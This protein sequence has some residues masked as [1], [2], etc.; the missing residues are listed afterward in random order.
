MPGETT[1]TLKATVL[2]TGCYSVATK[3]LPDDLLPPTGVVVTTPSYCTDA[4]R[5]DV[6]SVIF[7]VTNKEAISIR[8]IYWEYLGEL[9]PFTDPGAIIGSGTQVFN[10]PVG[11]YRTRFYSGDYCPGEAMGQVKT[12]I[13]SFNLVSDNGDNSNETWIID[14]ISNFTIA[15]GAKRDNNVKVFN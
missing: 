4:N 3:L 11:Y 14:C 8:D 6:G 1:Y 2:A 5:G 15:G 12:E 9:P 7:N 10:L 13:L